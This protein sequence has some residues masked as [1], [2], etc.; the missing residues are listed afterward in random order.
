MSCW[1]KFRL[2]MCTTS[3]WFSKGDSGQGQH[4]E[5]RLVVKVWDM[6]WWRKEDFLLSNKKVSTYTKPEVFRVK[7]FQWV[8][9][10]VLCPGWSG[11]VMVNRAIGEWW[12]IQVWD[13][14][15]KVGDAEADAKRSSSKKGKE[16][17]GKAEYCKTGREHQ[18]ANAAFW[19]GAMIEI[20]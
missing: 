11:G 8:I 13:C 14:R 18:L 6:R 15:K 7:E 20:Q 2:K 19:G 5:K 4:Y 16:E 17:T 10:S 1:L 12:E 9:V 3:C